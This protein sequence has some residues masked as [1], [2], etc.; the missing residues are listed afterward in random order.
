MSPESLSTEGST[1]GVESCLAE[2]AEKMGG[3][4]KLNLIEGMEVD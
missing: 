1:A 3:R 2:S 4:D